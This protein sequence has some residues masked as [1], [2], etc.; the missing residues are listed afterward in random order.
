MCIE[1]YKG[2]KKNVI[3]RTA[4]DRVI[5]IQPPE[6]GLDQHQ[7]EKRALIK[8]LY[9]KF[10]YHFPKIISYNNKRN[11]IIMSY[12]GE[13]L[14]VLPD[15]WEN[16]AEEILEALHSVNLVH[17]DI[18]PR[19]LLI[20]DNK[21]KLIDLSYAGDPGEDYKIFPGRLGTDYR[22]YPGFDDR[23]SLFKSLKWI[24]ENGK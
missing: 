13:Q 18:I 10:N 21:I 23:Y 14:K 11:L 19:N 16:Q 4:E 3:K 7:R 2:H 8:L 12:C 22:K 5:K 24:G 20:L 17:R 1:V 6:Y 9:H 15:D